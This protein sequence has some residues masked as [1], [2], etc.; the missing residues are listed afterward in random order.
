MKNIIVFK[1]IL[2]RAF[3]ILTILPIYISNILSKSKYDIYIIYNTQQSRS[4]LFFKKPYE[5]YL[6]GGMPK[7]EVLSVF[8][9]LFIFFCFLRHFHASLDDS[10]AD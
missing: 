8:L 9:F 3:I 6:I 7:R 1:D 4:L 10:F 2:S 5:G